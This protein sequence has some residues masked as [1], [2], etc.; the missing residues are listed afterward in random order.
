[1]DKTKDAIEILKT[2]NQDHI[3]RL[4]DKL[5]GEKKQELIDQ[6]MKI[7][8]NQIHELYEKTKK[9][10]EIKENKIESIKYVDK[11]KLTKK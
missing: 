3:I 7:D 5:E 8:F 2:Y 11:S 9:E 10:I 6:I 1:M 4:L